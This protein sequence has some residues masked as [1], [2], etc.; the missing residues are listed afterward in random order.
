[1]AYVG[2]PMIGNIEGFSRLSTSLLIE[3][4][5]KLGGGGGST[6]LLTTGNYE[7]RNTLLISL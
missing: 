7:K 1:M 3:V 2:S 4:A 6:T 5:T